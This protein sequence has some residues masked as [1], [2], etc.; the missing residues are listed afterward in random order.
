MRFKA[1]F[2]DAANTLLHKPQL[3]PAI[4]DILLTHGISIP[5]D[6]ISTNHQLLSEVITF[7]DRTSREFYLGFNTHLLHLLG[8]VP[9]HDLLESIFTACSYL[10]WAPFAD[11]NELSNI[12]LPMGVISNWDTSLPEKLSLIKNTQFNWV[13]GS[14]K[15]GHRKPDASFFVKIME[16]TDFHAQDIIYVGDSLRLDIEPALALGINAIL[17]DRNQL[18]PYATV[19]RIQ[20]LGELRELISMP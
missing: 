5:V 7:P 20:N 11:T 19:P 18:Y 3:Y 13:L 15:E 6:R 16:C 12:H 14:A 4:R 9:T 1:I 2:F 10:P 8:I 17:I